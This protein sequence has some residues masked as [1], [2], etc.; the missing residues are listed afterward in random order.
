MIEAVIIKQIISDTDSFKEGDKVKII[1]KDEYAK[2]QKKEYAGTITQIN[3][4]GCFL[5]YSNV[6][7]PLNTNEMKS[8]ERV[9]EVDEFCKNLRKHYIFHMYI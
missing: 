8:I 7:I 3:S 1:L 2:E 5:S 9:N 6:S 4:D